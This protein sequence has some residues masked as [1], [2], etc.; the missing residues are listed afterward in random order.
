MDTNCTLNL[1]SFEMEV[2]TASGDVD[3]WMNAEEVRCFNHTGVANFR[4][5]GDVETA[6]W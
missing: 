3:L 1:N 4:F 6:E 2:Y 5:V